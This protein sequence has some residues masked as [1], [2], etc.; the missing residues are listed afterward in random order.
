MEIRKVTI[1]YIHTINTKK[2]VVDGVETEIPLV[3]KKGKPFTKMSLITKEIREEGKEDKGRWIG[4]FK[5]KVTE[6]WSVGDVVTIGIEEVTI[7]DGR[8]FLNFS[9]PDEKDIRIAELEAQ[10]GTTETTETKEDEAEG[11]SMPF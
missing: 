3:S 8:K 7:E 6:K 10:A 1:E 11:E 5:N 9:T 2:V 4:G